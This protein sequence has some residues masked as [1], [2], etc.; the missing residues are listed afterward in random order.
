MLA[1]REAQDLATRLIRETVDKQD[2]REDELAL[3]KRRFNIPGLTCPLVSP[4]TTTRA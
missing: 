1:H 2:V 4:R 3:Q